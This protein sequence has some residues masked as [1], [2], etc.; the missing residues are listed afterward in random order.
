MVF[1]KLEIK[2]GSIMV[3]C[4]ESSL[5]WNFY[6]FDYL[7]WL[8]MHVLTRTTRTPA[9]WDTPRRPMITHT[10]DSHQIPSQNNTKSKL[11]ILK[12]CQNFNTPSEVAL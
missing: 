2:M 11:Q 4:Y 1:S 12:N 5:S 8:E 10:S 3:N 6:R 9:F 7:Y